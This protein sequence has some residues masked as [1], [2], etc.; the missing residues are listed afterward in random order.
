MVESLYF[1]LERALPFPVE[2]L[3]AVFLRAAVLVTLFLLSHAALFSVMLYALDCQLQKQRIPLQR[4][5]LC[6]LAL[7]PAAGVLFAVLA[8]KFSRKG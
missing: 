8:R 6:Y 2:P 4:R 7:V 5:D 3:E 1:V